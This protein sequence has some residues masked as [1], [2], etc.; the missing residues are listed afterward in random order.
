MW[1]ENYSH[2]SQKSAIWKVT[3][4]LCVY[5]SVFFVFPPKPASQNLSQLGE[6]IPRRRLKVAGYKSLLKATVLLL[7]KKL[8]MSACVYV[9]CIL[10]PYHIGLQHDS[11]SSNV[12]KLALALKYDFSRLLAILCI[13]HQNSYLQIWSQGWFP[14]YFNCVSGQ[15]PNGR[16]V[17]FFSF[18]HHFL[19]T[20]TDSVSF[21]YCHLLA[22]WF[23]TP[24]FA[25]GCQNELNLD[26]SWRKDGLLPQ[27]GFWGVS[28]NES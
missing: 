11:P 27:F 22:K 24:I 25:S 1:E 19:C 23:P 2:Y 14:P 6:R 16:V 17:I 12:Q 15:E 21:I 13:A 4:V 3:L 9:L 8:S 18:W 20:P 28:A 7:F 5:L 10:V 26:G